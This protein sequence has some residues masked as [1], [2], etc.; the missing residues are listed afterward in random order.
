MLS[1]KTLAVGIIAFGLGA[2]GSVKLPSAAALSR[3]PK[4]E[5]PITAKE[6]PDGVAFVNPTADSR[7]VIVRLANQQATG[8]T[9]Y[10]GARTMSS[11]G[12]S[13]FLVYQVTRRFIY[14]DGKLSECVIAECPIP[15]PCPP[16]AECPW[17]VVQALE[18]RPSKTP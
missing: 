13:V 15:P 11:N 4:Q 12:A 1:S 10:E 18:L 8:F 7:F 6:V 14:Q 5:L 16:P 17:R 9:R 2:V 3:Q